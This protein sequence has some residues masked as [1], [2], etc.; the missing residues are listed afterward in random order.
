[1]NYLSVVVL[2]T[3]FL[4]PPEAIVSALIK[5]ELIVPLGI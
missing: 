5:T 4:R 1:L 2:E 3:V